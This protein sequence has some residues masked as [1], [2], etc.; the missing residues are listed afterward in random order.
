MKRYDPRVRGDARRAART[1]RT[2]CDTS[3][4][5]S[6]TR[7][8]SRTSSRARSS[9]AATCPRELIEATR[10]SEA[11][12]VEAAVG[13]GDPDVVRAFS[14]SFLGSLLHDL[15]VVH[16]AARG[17]GR[18]AA[19]RRSSA[20]DWWNEGRAV[21]GALRLANGARCDRAWIQLLAHVRVPRDDP[22]LL[23]R[24]G[25]HARVPVA[26]A[27]AV[28]RRS[29]GAASGGTGAQRRPGRSSRTTSRSRASCGTSTTAS[30]TAC[31]AGRRPSRR[32]STSTC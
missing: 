2:S 24:L 32:A 22:V 19:R 11:E 3:A 5:S 20:G 1:R 27:E 17:D 12:Q 13:S 30:S 15:N 31:R 8:S 14:E 7:S 16:G 28:A 29:T 10:R 6:T 26:L 21:Y 23:R 18:A 9:A 25:A 4:S